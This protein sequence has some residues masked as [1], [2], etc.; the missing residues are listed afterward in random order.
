[1]LSVDTLDLMMQSSS[2]LPIRR[3][4]IGEIASFEKLH[5]AKFEK[6]VRHL[7]PS[8]LKSPLVDWTHVDLLTTYLDFLQQR[9]S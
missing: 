6:Q 5:F 1:M 2:A 3:Q 9:G 4:H 8:S 7:T